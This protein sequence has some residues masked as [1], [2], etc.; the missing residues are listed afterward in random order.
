RYHP[1]PDLLAAS[2]PER[3]SHRAFGL[4]NLQFTEAEKDWPHKISMDAVTSMRI[5]IPGEPPAPMELMVAMEF[6]DKG[7]GYGF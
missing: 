6:L 7:D 3:G 2:D 1:L 4:P 5:D